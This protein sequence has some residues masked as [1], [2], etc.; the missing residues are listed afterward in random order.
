MPFGLDLPLHCDEAQICRRLGRPETT[1]DM[2]G[3]EHVTSE[4][5]ESL[6]ASLAISGN[7]RRE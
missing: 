6:S 5:S 4:L 7:P 3:T 1:P 2:Q